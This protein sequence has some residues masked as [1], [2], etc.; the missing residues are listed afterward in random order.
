MEGWSL[1]LSENNYLKTGYKT[2]GI[3]D[4]HFISDKDIENKT[5]YALKIDA[6][7]DAAHKLKIKN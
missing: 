6:V 2:D 1:T 4:I 5:S 3:L 7:T